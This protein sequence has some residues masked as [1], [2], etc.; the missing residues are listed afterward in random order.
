MKCDFKHCK[1]CDSEELNEYGNKKYHDECK[2]DIDNLTK[3]AELYTKYY[4]KNENYGIMMRSL[5]NWFKSHESEYMLFCISKV[6]REKKKLNNFW[7]LYYVITNRNYIRRYDNYLNKSDNIVFGN[8]HYSP[9]EK[10]EML[11]HMGT[12]YK[13]YNMA[14]K[15][16]EHYVRRLNDYII[17]TGKEYDSHA[18][19]IIEWYDRDEEKKPIKYKSTI[20]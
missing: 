12:T 10:V 1:H 7:S 8:V 2:V 17:K 14:S 18:E 5:Y 4:N 3:I 19:V 15:K 16:L 11:K 6:I 9:S 20:I 13:D